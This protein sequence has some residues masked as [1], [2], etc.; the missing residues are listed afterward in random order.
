MLRLMTDTTSGGAAQTGPTQAMQTQTMRAIVV[1]KL[2]A[3]D[4]MQVR[5]GVP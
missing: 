1:E 4:V 5:E 3:P 2:G